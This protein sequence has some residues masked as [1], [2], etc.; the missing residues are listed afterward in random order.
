MSQEIHIGIS[1]QQDVPQDF[2]DEF[3]ETVSDPSLQLKIE[4]RPRGFYASIEWALPTLVIAY[5]AKPYFEGFLQEA[6]KDHYQALKKGILQLT[7]R[8]Y[9]KHPERRE[10]KRSLLF[11]TIVS[12]QDGRSLKFIFPEGVAIEKFETAVDSMHSLLSEHFASHPGDR[13]TEIAEKL[14][15]PSRSLYFEFDPEQETWVLLDPLLEAQKEQG[16]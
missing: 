11:S 1:Y 3:S 8:L 6:G 10:R 4:S 9:G 15:N 16:T 2:I 7:H 13:I 5:L 12:L 14:S